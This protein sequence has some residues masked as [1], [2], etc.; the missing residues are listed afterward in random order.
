MNVPTSGKIY[1]EPE[2]LRAEIGDF[3]ARERTVVFGNGCFDLLHVGHIRYLEASKALGDILVVAV[4]TDASM[5]AIKPDR[6]PVTPERERF[7]I[8]AALEAVDYVVPLDERTPAELL[9]LLRPDVQTK[10]TDYTL[11]R[12]PERVVIEGY[13]GRVVIVGDPKSHSSSEIRER[14][15][16]PGAPENQ[17][18]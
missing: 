10:G 5:R 7:E 18:K 3:G 9:G 17:R 4:N 12:I 15:R 6:P 16:S 8:V 2:R 13:G 11:E 14:L 1:L